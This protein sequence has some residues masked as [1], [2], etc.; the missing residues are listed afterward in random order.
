MFGY[1][2]VT[3]KYVCSMTILYIIAMIKRDANLVSLSYTSNYC[4]FMLISFI[5]FIL[6]FLYNYYLIQQLIATII[7]TLDLSKSYNP[8]SKCHCHWQKYIKI[9]HQLKLQ[10]GRLHKLKKGKFK[11]IIRRTLRLRCMM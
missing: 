5:S 7:S 11:C 4:F 9:F 10:K 8:N 1:T 2:S 6:H 3:Q